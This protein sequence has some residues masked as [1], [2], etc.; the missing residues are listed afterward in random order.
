MS[1]K[2]EKP[3]GQWKPEKP[4]GTKFRRRV[5][6][7]V[8]TMACLGAAIPGFLSLYFAGWVGIQS[9]LV[10]ILIG[11]AIFGGGT[12]FLRRWFFLVI[13]IGLLSLFFAIPFSHLD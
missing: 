3:T 4:T 1:D 9:S 6:R 2:P 12:Y 10:S 13:A 7:F 5:D 11:A 8:V